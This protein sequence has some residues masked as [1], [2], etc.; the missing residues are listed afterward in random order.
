MKPDSARAVS[1]KAGRGGGGGG[2]GGGDADTTAGRD[3]AAAAAA[4]AAFVIGCNSPGYVRFTKAQLAMREVA[5]GLAP[6]IDRHMHAR[7]CCI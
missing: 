5:G 4:A 3:G 6:F 1:G 7:G 2:G